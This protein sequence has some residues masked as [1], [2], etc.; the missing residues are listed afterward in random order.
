MDYLLEEGKDNLLKLGV[1]SK[2]ELIEYLV[3]LIGN[4]DKTHINNILK[5]YGEETIK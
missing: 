1:G 3:E 4:N 5:K 2:D